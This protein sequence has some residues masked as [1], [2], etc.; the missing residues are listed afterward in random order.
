[1]GI[2]IQA[3]KQHENIH[4]MSDPLYALQK[5]T[6]F[7]SDLRSGLYE[8]KE[9]A[10]LGTYC[11]GVQSIVKLVPNLW[12]GLLAIGSIAV[13]GVMVCMMMKNGKKTGDKENLEVG[14]LKKDVP[15][16]GLKKGDHVAHELGA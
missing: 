13:V 2:L 7:F 11:A 10:I 12:T 9:T 1:M 15:E 16:H 5:S 14:K 3:S 8:H 6:D 4:K